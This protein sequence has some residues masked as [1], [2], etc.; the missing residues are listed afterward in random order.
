MCKQEQ[1]EGGA[2]SE[3]TQVGLLL[4]EGPSLFAA[5][6]ASSPI[7]ADSELDIAVE[8]AYQHEHHALSSCVNAAPPVV[9]L[10]RRCTLNAG[11]P[12]FHAA[13]PCSRAASPSHHDG[14]DPAAE[15]EAEKGGTGVRGRMKQQQEPEGGAGAGVRAGGGRQEAE[16]GRYFVKLEVCATRGVV[17]QRLR[18]VP[19]GGDI[20]AAAAKNEI[21]SGQRRSRSTPDERYSA[22]R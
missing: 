19:P 1:A 10:T 14:A 16:K 12:Y 15:G 6:H 20:S 2:G 13:L 11:M 8:L 9:V 21:V 22:R 7:D 17:S 4:L 3:R 18:L 5:P